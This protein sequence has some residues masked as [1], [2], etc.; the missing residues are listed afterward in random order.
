MENGK[1]TFVEGDPNNPINRG[2][3]CKKG[4]ASLEYLNHPD[5]LKHPLKRVGEKGKGSWERISWD[6]ALDT[7]AQEL[8][9]LKEKYGASSVVF[10]RGAAKGLQDDHLARFANIFGSPNISAP[11]QICFVPG[12]HASNIT[13]G[14][15]AFPDYNYPPKCII[16]WGTNPEATQ[17][18]QH[19]EILNALKQGTKLIVIDPVENDLCMK[20]DIWLRLRPNTD[21]ALA[22]GLMNVI[23]VENLYDQEFVRSWTIGFDQLKSHVKSYNLEEV[24][25]I[26]WV[27]KEKILKAA[28]L[29]SAE[30]PACIQWGNGIETTINSFQA[31]RAIAILRSL[32]GNLG[33]PGGEVKWSDPG[34]VISASRSP[35]FLCQQNIPPDVRAKRLSAGENMMPFIFYTT[36]QRILKAILKGDPYQVYGAY[37]KGGNMLISYP[38]AKETYKALMKLKF[39]VVADMFMTPTAML[40]DIILPVAT[41]LEFDHVERLYPFPVVSVQQKTARIGECWSDSKIINELIKKIGFRELAW[42]NVNES[43]DLMLK[44][45]GITFEEFRNIGV[46][47]GNRLY[48][49]FE[50]D[51]FD[52][53]SKKVEIYSKTLEEWGFDPLPVYHEPPETPYSEPE[54]AKDYPLLLTS[55]KTD[56]YRHSGGRQFP[57]LRKNR[58]WPR[59]KIHPDTANG[60]GLKEDDWAYIATRRGKIK[61][62]VSFNKALDPRV[63]EADYAWWFPEKGKSTLYGWEES[64]LNILTNDKPPYNREMGSTNVRGFS[65]KVYK[66]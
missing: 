50:I 64:N 65:C 38:N 48:R 17:V 1:P 7:I 61:Q 53:P 3:L 18:N 19:A 20:A 37:I 57:S 13:Y 32:T 14:Y 11:T 10:M 5:R 62:K 41:Y 46:L 45:A 56:V 49:H 6:E 9:E 39:L 35:E 22:L 44:P 31:C 63:I 30:K 59:L 34:G 16:V 26:T 29:F 51:G 2:N 52:T 24:E 47:I 15:Y 28:R 43:F 40:A 21:L 25:K 36:H 42:D 55:R 8:T 58:P 54:L 66:A 33:V 4:S 23:L 27:P 60:L 12:I